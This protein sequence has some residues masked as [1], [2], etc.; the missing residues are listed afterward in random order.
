MKVSEIKP[1]DLKEYLRIDDDTQLDIMLKSAKEYVKSYAGLTDEQMDEHEDISHAIFVLV[2]DMYD[3][4]A[5]EAKN[6]KVNKV[7]SSIL[8]M[9]STNLL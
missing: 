1:S 5:L 7:V 8:N 2:S 6:D 4:R 9:Y 3:N